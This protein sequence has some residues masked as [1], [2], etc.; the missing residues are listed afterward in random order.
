MNQ[1]IEEYI[2][3]CIEENPYITSGQISKKINEKLKIE[4]SKT[5]IHSV[6]KKH[7]YSWSMPVKI[8]KKWTEI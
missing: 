7:N 1:E 8:P 6:L 5:S 3:L 2:I 4:F